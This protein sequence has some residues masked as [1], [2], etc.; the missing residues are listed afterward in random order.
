MSFPRHL[1]NL[2]REEQK[3]I[4]TGSVGPADAASFD[5]PKDVGVSG[6]SAL[7]RLRRLKC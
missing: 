6:S 4:R 1:S 5:T 2:L 3:V 7:A